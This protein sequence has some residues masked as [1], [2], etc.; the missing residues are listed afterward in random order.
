VSLAHRFGV[1]ISVRRRRIDSAPDDANTLTINKMQ[2]Q[3]SSYFMINENIL[4][5]CSDKNVGLN[6]EVDPHW[7]YRG[8]G[9]AAAAHVGLEIFP[10]QFSMPRK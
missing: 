10:T 7:C 5:Y 3:S 9:G 4:Q 8:G 2:Q 1:V 6:S